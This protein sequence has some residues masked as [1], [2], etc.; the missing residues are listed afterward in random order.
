[1]AKRVLI[2]EDD[3]GTREMFQL[4][5]VADGYAV[6]VRTDG[7]SALSR[8]AG[9]PVDLVVLDVMMPNLDGLEV[10]RELRRRPGWE[11]TPVIVTTARG[12]DDAVW[13]GWRAGADYYLVKPFELDELRDVAR[14][15]VERGQVPGHRLV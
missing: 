3:P 4:M 14:S 10:L 9:P 11:E 1:M 15:L 8:L 7:L 2:V 13:E 6:E 12:A 5:F